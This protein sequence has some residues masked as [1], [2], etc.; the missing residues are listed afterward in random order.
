MNGSITQREMCH[1]FLHDYPVLPSPPHPPVLVFSAKKFEVPRSD[2]GD[3]VEEANRREERA[4][5]EAR[6]LN[7]AV[8]VQEMNEMAEATENINNGEDKDEDKEKTKANQ[9]QQQVKPQQLTFQQQQAKKNWGKLK[10]VAKIAGKSGAMRHTLN[11]S[12]FGV[13]GR[14]P[15]MNYCIPDAPPARRRFGGNHGVQVRQLGGVM[16]PPGK[17]RSEVKQVEGGVGRWTL[18]YPSMETEKMKELKIRTRLH[19][20][21]R[22]PTL[23]EE[24]KHGLF[25]EKGGNGLRRGSV[26]YGGEVGKLQRGRGSVSGGGGET[27]IE[28]EASEEAASAETAEPARQLGKY[29]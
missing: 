20:M 18:A 16:K 3:W 19:S 17:I 26:E 12:I 6:E 15:T 27:K 28:E 14:P 1:E 8:A 13:A 25:G 11:S 23:M 7:E 21:E 24:G 10:G 2:R 5:E 29:L 4:L 9:S 22:R